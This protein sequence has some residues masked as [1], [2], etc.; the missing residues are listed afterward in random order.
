MPTSQSHDHALQTASSL[1]ARHRAGMSLQ[2]PFYTSQELFDLD[3]DLIRGRHWIHVGVEPD[4]PANEN[5]VE[6]FTRWYH[7]RLWD[8]VQLAA[9]HRHPA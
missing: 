3:L 4:L 8:G 9:P 1:L 2:A 5:Q 6:A 7:D